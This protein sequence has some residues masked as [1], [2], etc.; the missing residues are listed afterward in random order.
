MDRVTTRVSMVTRTSVPGYGFEM[1]EIF[2]NENNE[3]IG[4]NP[5]PFVVQGDDES[6]LTEQIYVIWRAL[7]LNTSLDLDQLDRDLVSL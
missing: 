6:E 7:E 5:Q 4:Y 2:Y 1:R 3:V